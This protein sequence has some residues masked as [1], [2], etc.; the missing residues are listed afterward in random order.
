M[1]KKLLFAVNP[2]AGKSDIKNC[3]LPILQLF[4]ENEYETT[5][6]ISRRQ[7]EI[8]ETLAKRAG[9]YDLVVCCG[10]DGTL[11][12]TVNG[13][14]NSGVDVPMGYI[15]TGTVND[16]ASNQHLSK[17]MLQAAKNIFSGQR[18]SA[19]VGCFNGRYFT[20]VA[21]FGAFSDVAYL[22]PQATKA[23]LGRAA[24]FFEGVKRLPTLKPIKI[25]IKTESA[26][27]RDEFI[28]G[29]VSN[30]NT[31][32][33][34]KLFPKDTIMCDDGLMELTL[35][36]NPKNFGETQ[37]AA[38]SMLQGAGNSPMIYR[39][40]V[41]KAVFTGDEAISWTL[42]GEFGGTVESAEIVA[43]SPG[44]SLMK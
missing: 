15:P 30:Y 24:Y 1:G 4:A 27:I 16:F 10:G 9:E 29:M 28:F 32:G 41:K 35:V 19:D 40:H 2:K 6:L 38:M 17:N 14:L 43:V 39:M 34:M 13:I 25:E 44:I 20:Y 5:M 33:G 22:T 8:W 37:E 3:L 11:N 18:T 21:A 26:V 36:K 31:I 12:E 7:G 42:D 23:T